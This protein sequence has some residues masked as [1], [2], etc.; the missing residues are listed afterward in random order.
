MTA[1]TTTSKSDT[2]RNRATKSETLLKLLRTKRGASVAQ[3][4]EASGWQAHS[5]RGFLS[6]TVKRKLGLTLIAETSKDGSKR[7]RIDSGVASK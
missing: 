4:Q 7:Y 5:V 3:M 6:G 2:L 1:K